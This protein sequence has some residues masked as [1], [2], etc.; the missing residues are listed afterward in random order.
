M[1]YEDLFEENSPD[2]FNHIEHD[3]LGLVADEITL[4][5][6]SQRSGDDKTV[7]ENVR[8]DRKP[9]DM[10]L[11]VHDII[12]VWFYQKFGI[13]ARSQSVF[14]TPSLV[15][16]NRYGNPTA[17]LPK[18]DATYIFSNE[19]KDLYHVLGKAELVKQF[20]DEVQH[21]YLN[22]YI[23]VAPT[24]VLDISEKMVNEYDTN[25]PQPLYNEFKK[26]IGLV[27]EGLNYTATDNLDMEVNDVEVMIHCN[28]FYSVGRKSPES[29]KLEAKYGYLI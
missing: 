12:D 3:G 16:A 5:R 17:V 18:G 24:S 9:S 13:K 15:F 4:Y 6:G 7:I 20:K 26:L 10:P 25:I 27:M 2:L 21:P 11:M 28:Q 22:H 1:R 19:V 23:N 14:T 29:Y 8:F